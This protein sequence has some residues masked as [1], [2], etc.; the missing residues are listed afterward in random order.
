MFSLALSGVTAV[1]SGVT[2]GRVSAQHIRTSAGSSGRSELLVNSSS[3]A[4]LAKAV[5]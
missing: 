3:D 5:H 2:V 1:H 4:L